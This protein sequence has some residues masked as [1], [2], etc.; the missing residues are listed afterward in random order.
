MLT[1]KYK[2]KFFWLPYKSVVDASSKYSVVGPKRRDPYA[3]VWFEV[4]CDSEIYEQG[5]NDF[6]FHQKKLYK[7]RKEMRV[8]QPFLSNELLLLTNKKTIKVLDAY[9]FSNKT[10]KPKSSF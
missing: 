8:T 7:A 2:D 10:N 5:L 9:V 1:G 6:I 3:N 4:K